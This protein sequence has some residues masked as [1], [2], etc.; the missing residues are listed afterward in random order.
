MEPI[1]NKSKI[2]SAKRKKSGQVRL[3]MP[4]FIADSEVDTIDIERSKLLVGG[5]LYG[6]ICKRNG[7]QEAQLY[8]QTKKVVSRVLNVVVSLDGDAQGPSRLT[9]E[10]LLSGKY[11]MLRIDRHSVRSELADEIESIILT[12]AKE[13]HPRLKSRSMDEWLQLDPSL[14][15]A[16][17]DHYPIGL[18][19]VNSRVDYSKKIMSVAVIKEEG[20]SDHVSMD[21]LYFKNTK[22]RIIDI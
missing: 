13:R 1:K 6:D 20:W 11:G 3:L 16:L 8:A 22:I 10:D 7:M 12:Q 5:C 9:T 14:S 15:S 4:V 2:I 19:I 21:V 17:F 18:I